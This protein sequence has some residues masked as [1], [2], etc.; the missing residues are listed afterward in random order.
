MSS[1]D[2]EKEYHRAVERSL[3]SIEDHV[4]DVAASLRK[5]RETNHTIVGKFAC[6]DDIALSLNVLPEL[7]RMTTA[8]Y[9]KVGEVDELRR[10][11]SA[12][13]VS[14]GKRVQ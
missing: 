3:S 12:L 8:V 2:E 4:A 14:N 13:E 1:S 11:V 9:E 7:V 6:L 5:L 10:R